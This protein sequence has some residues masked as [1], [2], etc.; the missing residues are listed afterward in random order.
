ML[1]GALAGLFGVWALDRATWFMWNREGPM[2][3]KQDVQARPGGL[4]PAHRLVNGAANAAGVALVPEQPHPA[5]MVAHYLLAAVQGA[6]YGVMRERIA[7]LRWSRRP[8]R[9]RFVSCAG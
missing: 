4:D 9:S 8:V 6:F 3:L 5:G 7:G 2:A 1:K